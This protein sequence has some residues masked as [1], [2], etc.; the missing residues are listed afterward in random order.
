MIKLGNFGYAKK[1]QSLDNSCRK[2]EN[3]IYCAP[4]VIGESDF[5]KY[6]FSA[7][8]WSFGE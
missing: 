7:D 4:E 3:I 6:S 1:D 8:V 5:G 2:D